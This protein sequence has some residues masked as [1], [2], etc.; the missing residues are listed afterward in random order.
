MV[1]ERG[2]MPSEP[3]EIQSD[4]LRSDSSTVGSTRPAAP[5]DRD[6]VVAPSTRGG[7]PEPGDVADLKVETERYGTGKPRRI[8][9]RAKIDHGNTD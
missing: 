4:Y 7:R 9:I 2:W 6:D 8:V 5:E 1:S 3:I